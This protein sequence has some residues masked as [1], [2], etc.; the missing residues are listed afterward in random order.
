[1]TY[2]HLDDTELHRL[3]RRRLQDRPEGPAAWQM[4]IDDLR[5]LAAEIR[6]RLERRA[7]GVNLTQ[8]TPNSSNP[9]SGIMTSAEVL[10]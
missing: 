9:K 5:D 2:D 8:L 3:V 6:G 7:G 10:S 1:M 4:Q